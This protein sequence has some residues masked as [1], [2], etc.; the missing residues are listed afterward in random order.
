MKTLFFGVVTLFLIVGMSNDA[1]A[2]CGAACQAKCRATH[3]TLVSCDQ[4]VAKRSKLNENQV[5]ARRDSETCPPPASAGRYAA[6]L[7]RFK[8]VHGRVMSTMERIRYQARCDCGGGVVAGGLCYG[9][10]DRAH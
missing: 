7:E 2:A 9:G 5:E 10:E 6:A 4:C 1:Q 8:A 3:N